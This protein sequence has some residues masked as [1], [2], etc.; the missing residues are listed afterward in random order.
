MTKDS[1]H[2]DALLAK[3]VEAEGFE[4]VGSE[5]VHDFGEDGLC[6]Y[7]DKTPDGVSAKDCGKV[8]EVLGILMP[9]EGLL[10][11]KDSLHVSSPGLARP[12][13]Q[14]KQYLP[15]IGKV[16]QIKLVVSQQGRRRF[17]GLLLEVLDDAIK[18]EVDGEVFTFVATSIEK[19]NVCLPNKLSQL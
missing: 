13:F 9:V 18:L 19:A 17:K 5:R 1:K 4:Y 12:L 11:P 14:L 15:F 3:A 8:S 16:I 7:I 6:V 2:R 10:G